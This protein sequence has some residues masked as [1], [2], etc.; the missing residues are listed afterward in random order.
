MITREFTEDDLTLSNIAYNAMNGLLDRLDI[1]EMMIEPFVQLIP[2]V[3]GGSI[4]LLGLSADR[5]TVLIADYKFGSVKVSPKESPN[6]GLYAGSARKDKTT[7]DL[8]DCV[9]RVVFAII[10][11]RVK[12]VVSTWETDMKWVNKFIKKFA[13]Q[14]D[15]TDINPGPHCKYCRAEPYCEER[16]LNILASNLL[17][18]KDQEELRAAADIVIEVEDWMKSV[19]E[20]LYL[21]MTRGVPIPGWKIVA[22]RAIRKWINEAEAAAAIKLAQKDKYKTTLLSPT[23]MER[24]VKTKKVNIDLTPFIKSESGGTTLAP[25]NDSR[26]AVLASDIIGHLD[27]LVK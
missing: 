10:Q 8:F 7:A 12:G 5:K 25:E 15:K 4:D 19:K 20:E 14:M 13:A 27:T 18:V 11:P 21:Q 17:G 9:E 26:D 6:L 23:Q 2:G 24:V 3:A 22:K 16:R 1:D